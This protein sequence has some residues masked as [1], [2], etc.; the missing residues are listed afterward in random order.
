LGRLARAYISRDE[1]TSFY[2]GE[3][4]LSD[5]AEQAL[6]TMFTP[7]K[8]FLDNGAKQTENVKEATPLLWKT[9][10]TLFFQT[11]ALGPCADDLKDNWSPMVLKISATMRRQHIP[12]S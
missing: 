4:E 6:S 5:D 11:R 9:P 7:I 12:L 10:L 1:F 8:T 3:R 2:F